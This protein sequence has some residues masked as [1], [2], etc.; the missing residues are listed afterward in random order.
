MCIQMCP[1]IFNMW[2]FFRFTMKNDKS[3]EPCERKSNDITF[4]WCGQKNATGVSP[5]LLW[6]HRAQNIANERRRVNNEWP[7]HYSC[8]NKCSCTWLPCLI[9]SFN[10]AIRLRQKQS[11]KSNQGT[12]WEREGF[13]RESKSAGESEFCYISSIFLDWYIRVWWRLLHLSAPL[14]FSCFEL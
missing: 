6:G 8:S 3:I 12:D 13:N 14:S 10:T 5:S 9:C 4:L 1:R 2:L 7:I 11:L